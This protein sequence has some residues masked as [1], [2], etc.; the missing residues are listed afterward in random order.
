M[1]PFGRFGATVADSCR[2]G[3]AWSMLEAAAV[4][5]RRAAPHDAILAAPGVSGEAARRGG[6][7]ADARPPR[8]Q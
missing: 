4:D 1:A 8:P 2:A 7:V 3:C 6:A 5:P